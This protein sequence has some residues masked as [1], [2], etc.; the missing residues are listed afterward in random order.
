[1]FQDLKAIHHWHHDV[2]EDQIRMFLASFLQSYTTILWLDHVLSSV[3]ETIHQRF[4]D[5]PFIFRCK[6]FGHF[7]PLAFHNGRICMD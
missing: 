4:P 3:E 1:L 6:Y 7:R 2:T 5:A